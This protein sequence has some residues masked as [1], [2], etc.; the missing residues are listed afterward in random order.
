MET[1]RKAHRGTCVPKLRATKGKDQEAT[2]TLDGTV[3]G[4]DTKQMENFV[5]TRDGLRWFS[6]LFDG[7]VFF[8][9]NR[10]ASVARRTGPRVSRRDVALNKSSRSLLH[11]STNLQFCHSEEKRRG[12]YSSSAKERSLLSRSSQ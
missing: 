1:P 12:I 9:R 8:G 7:A 5:V 11:H 4:V 3:K 2:W 10:S 6:T